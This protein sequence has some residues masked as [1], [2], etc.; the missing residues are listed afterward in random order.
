MAHDR[1][2]ASEFGRKIFEK[3]SKRAR[4]G[5]PTQ[6]NIAPWAAFL[7]SSHASHITGQAVRVNG[8]ISAA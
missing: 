5:V 6:A 3:A 8:G 2:M 1:V 7:A 4:L